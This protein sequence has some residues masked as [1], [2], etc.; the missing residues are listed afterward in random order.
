[1][2]YIPREEHM[3]QEE[4]ANVTARYIAGRGKSSIMLVVNEQLIFYRSNVI[5]GRS[6]GTMNWECAGRRKYGCTARALTH[7]GH[8]EGV[9]QLEAGCPVELV[10]IWRSHLHTCSYGEYR[11]HIFTEDIKNRLKQ[12]LLENPTLKYKT[13]FQESKAFLISRIPSKDI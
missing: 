11:G 7:R 13:A 8:R 12:S 6:K 1:M 3:P 10:F 9:S 4:L 2:T 5:K